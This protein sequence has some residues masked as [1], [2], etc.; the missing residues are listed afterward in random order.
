MPNM[1]IRMKVNSAASGSTTATATAAR[2]LPRNAPSSTSTI[3]V[4]S[5]NALETV[6]TAFFTNSARL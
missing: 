2:T 5:T 1:R 3:S 6:P 4:A